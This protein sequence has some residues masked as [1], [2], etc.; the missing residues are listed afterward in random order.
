MTTIGSWAGSFDWRAK[1]GS[2]VNKTTAD[3]PPMAA[4]FA[5][6]LRE[7]M[8]E[9]ERDYG[10]ASLALFG[11][12]VRGEERDDSDLDV[13]VDF[14][15][16]IGLFGLVATERYMAEILGVR[17]DLVTRPALRRRIGRAI[18]EEAVPL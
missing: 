17:V 12:Y 15:R 13:L 4:E 8:P 3:M 9:L 6:I 10:V 2:S 18:L 14:S 7:H 11:S 16:P 5:R 1:A